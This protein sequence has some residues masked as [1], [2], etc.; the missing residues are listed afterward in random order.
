MA[1]VDRRFAVA[2]MIDY[3]DR[4]FRYLI[5]L[6]APKIL[7]YTEMISSAALYHAS[8]KKLL[9][10]H[11]IEHPIAIQL[12][13]NHPEELSWCSRLAEDYGYDEINLNLGCPSNRVQAGQFGACL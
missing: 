6:L 9:D 11:P 10:Y 4:H 12:G 7:L 8:H 1:I 3:T 2:P 5:R 13:G